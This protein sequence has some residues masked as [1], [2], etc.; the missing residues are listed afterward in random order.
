M[1][2]EKVIKEL[3]SKMSKAVAHT[4]HEF[5][6]LHTG[7]ASPSMVENI[8]V[9]A[10]GSAMRVK[11]V[12]AIT[13]PE[14]RL[15]NVQPWDKGL[16]QA[17]SKAI[18]AA[19]IGINPAVDGAVVR[20]P[21]PELS[22]ERRQEMV[23]VVSRMAEDGKINVRNARR[24][25]LDVLKKLQKSGIISEDELKRY[26]KD[27]QALT[28]KNVKEIGEHLENKEKELLKV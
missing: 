2:A 18:L 25:G 9:D 13:T 21:V 7:K 16:L 1:D 14:P 26:E 11:E 23:K 10:Y 6:T 19:N 5:N 28:D 12:A 4:L 3:S 22:R 24:D 17:V 15:I 20:C 27:V 8:S